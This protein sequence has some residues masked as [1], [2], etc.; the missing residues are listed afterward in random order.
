[1]LSDKKYEQLPA[2]YCEKVASPQEI[3]KA[4][5]EYIILAVKKTELVQEIKAELTGIYAVP[6]EKI[7]CIKDA[8][9]V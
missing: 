8:G 4:D 1:M 5:Y 6:E 9:E 2:M 7:L 3:S